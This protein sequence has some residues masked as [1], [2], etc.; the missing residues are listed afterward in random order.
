MLGLL[1]Q[2]KID[3]IRPYARVRRAWNQ[4]QRKRCLPCLPLPC[5]AARAKVMDT[6]AAAPVSLAAAACNATEWVAFI[7]CPVSQLGLRR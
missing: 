4:S 2:W 1:G 3:D 5:V 7:R 6:A